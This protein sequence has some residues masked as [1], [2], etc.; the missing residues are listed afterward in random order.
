VLQSLVNTGKISRKKFFKKCG[1][2]TK[3]VLKRYLNKRI[4]KNRRKIKSHPLDD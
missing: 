3:T 1:I 4:E 2:K